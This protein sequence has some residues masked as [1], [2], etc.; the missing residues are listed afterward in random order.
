M[1][2][3]ELK[4]GE[5]KRDMS[6]SGRYHVKERGGE[7][8]ILMQGRNWVLD[9]RGWEEEVPNKEGRRMLGVALRSK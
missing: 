5:Q 7:E 8:V 3:F 4:E 9:I 2:R 1:V 6:K